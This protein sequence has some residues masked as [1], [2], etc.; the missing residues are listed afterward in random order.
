LAGVTR[1]IAVGCD[2]E[3]SERALELA[4]EHPEVFAVIGHHPNYA[5]SFDASCLARY[6]AMLAHPR[7]VALGEIGLD[8][9]WDFATPAEQSRCL[10]AQFE[11]ALSTEAP[12]VIHCR[13]AWDET[14]TF[15]E[16]RTQ[17]P[18]LFHCFSG[19][20]AQCERGIALGAM[21][22]FDGP[23]TYKSADATR[24]I[25]RMIPHDRLVVETDSPYMAP[26]P[27]RGQPNKPAWV[28]YVNAAMAS[29][30]GITE[31]ECARLTTRNAERYFR[32]PTPLGGSAGGVPESS[33]AGSEG[34]ASGREGFSAC[35]GAGFDRLRGFRRVVDR[36]LTGSA[37]ILTLG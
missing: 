14:L 26:V 8:N 33:G 22:G 3:S 17:V 12:I 34:G 32:F 6:E 2:L 10:E 9:H 15:L 19:D 16:H 29:T 4:E 28:R 13:E 21:F 27:H 24:A 18:L 20:R 1:L 5:T 37:S 31:D 30:L 35:A 7:V 11:L 23:L 36:R 25:V